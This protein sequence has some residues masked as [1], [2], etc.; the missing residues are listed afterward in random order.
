[1]MPVEVKAGKS[2]SLKSLQQF[3]LLKPSKLALRFDLNP[4]SLQEVN[5]KVK[6][7]G[8][9]EDVDFPLLSIPLYAIEELPRLVDEYRTK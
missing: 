2:G 7:N 6:V 4:I 5:C 8:A 3:M 9:V 1:M